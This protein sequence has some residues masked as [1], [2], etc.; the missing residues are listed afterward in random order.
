MKCYVKFVF[1]LKVNSFS[2]TFQEIASDS[3]T[4]K[5]KGCYGVL[6]FTF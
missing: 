4:R 1:L 2:P 5:T 6:L 3:F